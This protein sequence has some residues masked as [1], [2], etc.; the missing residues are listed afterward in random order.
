MPD[1]KAS[2]Q[3]RNVMGAVGHRF[4]VFFLAPESSGSGYS[5]ALLKAWAY[6]CFGLPERRTLRRGF[7]RYADLTR[8]MTA[9][10]AMLAQRAANNGRYDE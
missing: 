7:Q 4:F 2:V 9:G 5:G 1:G 10:V 8:A 3:S 6:G